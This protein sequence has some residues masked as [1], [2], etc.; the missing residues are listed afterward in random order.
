MA[1]ASVRPPQYS[2]IP[3]ATVFPAT[4]RLPETTMI[5]SIRWCALFLSMLSLAQANPMTLA[6]GKFSERYYASV[7][8]DREKLSEV[9]RPAIIQVYDRERP[10]EPIMTIESEELIFDVGKISANEHELPYDEQSLLIYEDFNFDGKKDLALMDGQ[11]SCYHGPSFQVYLADGKGGF[12]HNPS[13]TLLA[14]EYCGFFEIDA[15]AK[16]LN[17]MTKS[18]CC[19]HLYEKYKVDGEHVYLVYSFTDDA[20]ISQNYSGGTIIEV[21][22]KGEKTS[23]RYRL[24][25]EE[26]N[27]IV[28]RFGLKSAPHKEV[29]LFL[30]DDADY[31]LLNRKNGKDVE[32]EYSYELAAKGI[33]PPGKH[34]DDYIFTL[35]AENNSLCFGFGDT[36]YTVLDQP[37]R[38]GVQVKQGQRMSFLAGDPDT[39]AGELMKI[40]SAENVKAGTCPLE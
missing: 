18:G 19:W 32:V 9:F 39:R 16:T 38:L 20:M 12:V 36:T 13:F 26:T 1:D 3:A 23:L 21:G 28:L 24:K 15:A 2:H 29:A 22:A 7:T 27:P 8:V 30:G 35:D 11:Y 25:E 37:G 40:R 10:E 34:R 14:Q 5:A 17:V 6:I 4:H 33:M 31:A